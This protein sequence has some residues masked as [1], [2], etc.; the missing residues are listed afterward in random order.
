MAYHGY[1]PR[2]HQLLMEYQSPRIL[3]VGLLHG[4]TLISLAH[5]LSHTHR[6][7]FY[8]G[9]DIKLNKSMIETLKWSGVM[10]R[11]NIK[12]HNMNSLMFLDYYKN[13]YDLILIDGDHN[14]LTVKRELSS[15]KDLCHKNTVVVVDDY[16]GKHSEVDTFYATLPGYE[17]NEIATQPVTTEKQGVKTAV[18]E[19]LE[20]NEIWKSTTLMPGE[21]IVLFMDGNRFFQRIEQSENNAINVRP[22]E[23]IDVTKAP[24][25]LDLRLSE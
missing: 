15:L 1:I 18:D 19:F 9:V 12:L 24:L 20:N 13:I 22:R 14:Y 25:S 5:R 8:E 21:P 17:Q 6:E 16:F 11:A 2:L 4:V 3:E 7:Y 10:D 23:W